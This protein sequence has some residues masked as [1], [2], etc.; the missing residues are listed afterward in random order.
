MRA[1]T[2][3]QKKLLDKWYEENKEEEQRR[4]DFFDWSKCDYFSL[5]F[6]E[7]LEVI[8]DTEILS[9]NVNRYISDKA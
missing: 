9:Q 8:N 2:V 1:L 4:I 5:E 3:R 7:Q 6:F